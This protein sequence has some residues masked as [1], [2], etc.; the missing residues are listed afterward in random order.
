MRGVEPERL[1][2][3]DETGCNVLLA[4]ERGWSLRGERLMDRRPGRHWQSISV[5][6][7]IRQDR[8]LCHQ[9]MDGALNTERWLEF[10]EK[11]LCP[12]LFPG[13]ILVLDNL[14]VHKNK[15]AIELIEA[16]GAEVK[17]QPPYSPEYNPIELTWAFLKHVLRRLRARTST[18][19]RKA[20]WRAL[21]RVTPRH[22]AG[23]FKHSGYGVQAK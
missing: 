11:K 22:L 13:D 9:S 16:T 2:F 19:L 6:A 10:V 15:R 8:V 3:L 14:K 18:A 23:W 20:V 7:A 17:F 12:T 1:V 21:L 4:P 5:V